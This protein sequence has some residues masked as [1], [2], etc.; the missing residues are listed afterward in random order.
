MASEQVKSGGQLPPPRQLACWPDKQQNTEQGCGRGEWASRLRIWRLPGQCKVQSTGSRAAHMVGTHAES[1]QTRLTVVGDADAVRVAGM[2]ATLFAGMVVRVGAG[3]SGLG[4][5]VVAFLFVCVVVR[6]GG[7]RRHCCAVL[8]RWALRG[9]WSLMRM[10]VIV[11][12]VGVGVGRRRGGSSGV[13]EHGGRRVGGLRPHS[14]QHQA[15][16]GQGQQ[17]GSEPTHRRVWFRSGL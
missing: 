5:V 13:G 14:H 17:Q 11:V 12:V 7:S 2:A 1:L 6:S 9:C 10:V 8:S 4:G 15:Q 3:S 16:A